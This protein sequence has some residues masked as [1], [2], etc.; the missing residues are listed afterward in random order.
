MRILLDSGSQRSRITQKLKNRLGFVAIKKE[1]VSLNMFG[2]QT[3]S[4]Q[5]CDETDRK[6]P[7]GD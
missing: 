7:R 1:S 3:F 6:V 5:Q 2:S 4:R